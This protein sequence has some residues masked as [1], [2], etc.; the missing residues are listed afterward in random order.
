MKQEEFL[1]LL[2]RI[3]NGSADAADILRY[4]R[5]FNHFQVSDEWNEATMGGKKGREELLFHKIE[6]SIGQGAVVK[7]M[8][9]SWKRITAVAAMLLL[10]LTAG[11]LFFKL[12]QEKPSQMVSK[13]T[14][15]ASAT[16]DLIQLPDGSTVILSAGSRLTYPASFN[17]Q[18]TRE[19]YLTGKAFFDIKHLTHQPFIVHTGKVKTTVLG[20]AFDIDSR[21]EVGKIT[22]TVIRGKVIVNKES[23]TLG[24]LTPNQQ[25]V[26]NVKEDKATVNKINADQTVSWREKDLLFND[27]EFNQAVLLLQERFNVK[28]TIDDK[29]LAAAHFTT[30]LFENQ[31]LTDFLGLICDFNHATYHYNPTT[32]EAIIQPKLN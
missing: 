15:P 25:V 12:P 1:Q 23:K 26:Y 21:Q 17:G 22:V 6:Q 16:N 7:K 3:H 4:N 18:P 28:I 24:T 29:E 2:E 30:T 5:Y 9:Y 27:I 8:P 31:S 20:T 32:R 13:H 10:L 14:Q 11:L 19:V